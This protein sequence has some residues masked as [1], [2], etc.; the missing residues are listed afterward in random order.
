MKEVELTG[1]FATQKAK[2]HRSA[3]V[4]ANQ[5]SL[6]HGAVCHPKDLYS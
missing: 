1:Q 4:G 3:E 2:K 5:R 6:P